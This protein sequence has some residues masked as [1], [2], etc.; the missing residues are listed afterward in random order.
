MEIQGGEIPRIG[1]T[2]IDVFALT[3]TAPSICGDAPRAP[4]RLVDELLVVHPAAVA[5]TSLIHAWLAAHP[6][7]RGV[8][9]PK[10]YHRPARALSPA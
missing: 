6:A 9:Q 4:A 5:A 7:V 2:Q 3:G 1:I 8:G 10:P